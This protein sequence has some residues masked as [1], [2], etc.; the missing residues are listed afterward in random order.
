MLSQADILEIEQIIGYTFKEKQLLTTAFTHISYANEH[1]RQSNENLEFL[2]DGLL[3]FV[4]AEILFDKE[5]MSEGQMSQLRARIVSRVPLAEEVERL[6]IL[7]F[8]KIGSGLDFEKG[9]S[10]KFVSNLYE[11]LI[12]AIYK[13]SNYST[14][15]SF[16]RR[17]L[18]KHISFSSVD[19]KTKLQELLQSKGKKVEYKDTTINSE[20][21]R[22]A[23]EALI[24]GKKV[25]KG[26]GGSK[27]QAQQA[28]A[29]DVFKSFSKK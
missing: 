11:S 19:H 26:E 28:A 8:L 22:F 15:K 27:K 2:G 16:I 18:I 9:M 3:N 6:G 4:V 17:T 20:P 23:C 13:D 7:R 21:P 5:I 10:V 25:G 24:D 14:A 1:D 12:A 29:L